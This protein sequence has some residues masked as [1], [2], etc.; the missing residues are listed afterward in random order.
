M[1]T[2]T[3][4]F[5]ILFL[6]GVMA[7]SALAGCAAQSTY[8]Q[9][10]GSWSTESPVVTQSGWAFW[11]NRMSRSMKPNVQLTVYADA[12]YR[13]EVA[14]M[15]YQG[16]AQLSSLFGEGLAIKTR[17]GQV[18]AQGRIRIIEGKKMII[19]SETENLGTELTLHRMP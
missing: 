4:R 19:E 10:I 2:R 7:T 5:L 12:S 15:E 9:A 16:Q 11:K 8:V 3:R 6:L 13:V 17:I 1:P 14:G 18:E